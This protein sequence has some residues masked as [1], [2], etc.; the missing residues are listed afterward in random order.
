MG[1]K[2][3]NSEN[4]GRNSSNNQARDDEIGKSDWAHA[5][6]VGAAQGWIQSFIE[7]LKK[8]KKRF[9]HNNRTYILIC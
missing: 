8:K 7:P 5:H 4:F 9:K 3:I 6:S 1:P 2:F